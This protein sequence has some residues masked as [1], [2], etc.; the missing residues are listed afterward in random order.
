LCII[1]LTVAK[2]FF[3]CRCTGKKF[4]WAAKFYVFCALFVE[5]L[6]S[7]ANFAG[8]IDAAD[9]FVIWKLFSPIQNFT[10]ETNL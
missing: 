7:G 2:R 10:K 1:L 6:Y 8:T 3:G 9:A 5:I 4:V